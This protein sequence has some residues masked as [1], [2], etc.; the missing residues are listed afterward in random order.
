[1]IIGYLDPWGI[2]ISRCT[3]IYFKYSRHL[4]LWKSG[5]ELCMCLACCTVSYLSAYL[6]NI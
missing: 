6:P 5:T 1:M 4:E 2:D 3:Y